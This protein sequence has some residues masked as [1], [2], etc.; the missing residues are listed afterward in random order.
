VQE[1]F[2][3]PVLEAR[4]LWQRIQES[5]SDR[6]LARQ[7]VDQD[8]LTEAIDEA[9]ALGLTTADLNQSKEFRGGVIGLEEAMAELNAGKLTDGIQRASE[10]R[11]IGL[12]EARAELNAGKL[13]DGIQRASELRMDENEVDVRQR[14]CCK[15]PS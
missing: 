8:L 10:L 1:R 3:Q 7:S 5:Q 4:S 13:T 2:N 11:M 6:R 15:T 14:L 9:E 12:E